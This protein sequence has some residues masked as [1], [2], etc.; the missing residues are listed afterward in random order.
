MQKS[1][2][3]L[4]LI[5]NHSCCFQNKTEGDSAAVWPSYETNAQKQISFLCLGGAKKTKKNIKLAL[6]SANRSNKAKTFN[7]GV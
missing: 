1:L 3:Q 6:T 7:T 5:D 2:L 4:R